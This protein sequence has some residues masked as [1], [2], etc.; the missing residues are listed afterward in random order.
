M[1]LGV[2]PGWSLATYLRR[3]GELV[4]PHHLVQVLCRRQ[5]VTAKQGGQPRHLW[6]PYCPP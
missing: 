3:Q 5:G 1:T 2:A 6:Q 4:E